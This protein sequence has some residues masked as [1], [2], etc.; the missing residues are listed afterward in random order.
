MVVA[1]NV[2]YDYVLDKATGEPIYPTAIFGSSYGFRFPKITIMLLE[3]QKYEQ[4]KFRIDCNTTTELNHNPNNKEYK[5]NIGI[6][7]LTVRPITPEESE[8]TSSNLQRIVNNYSPLNLP[9]QIIHSNELENI[10]PASFGKYLL[11]LNKK[12]LEE[13]HKPHIEKLIDR[14]NHQF[15]INYEFDA[16]DNISISVL[17]PTSVSIPQGVD[18]FFCDNTDLCT[19]KPGHYKN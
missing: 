12:Y 15:K 14:L 17:T 18:K 7:P 6:S 8:F 3:S 1:N 11:G 13:L 4:N 19:T 5:V 10:N 16:K 9:I 2:F